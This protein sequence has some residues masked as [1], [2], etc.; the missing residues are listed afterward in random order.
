M[1]NKRT[2][3]SQDAQI[4]RLLDSFLPVRSS[5]NGSE[6]SGDTHLDEDS[7]AAFVEGNLNQRQS[8]PL[9]KHLTNCSFCRHITAELIKLDYV[10]AQVEETRSLNY[11]NET[12]PTKASEVLSGLL[13]RIFGDSA[14][15]V[16][17]H[18]EAETG[19]EKD[20]AKP[21]PPEENQK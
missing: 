1:E 9:V 12:E 16:F 10:F 6:L 11:A 20:S 18:N 13:S 17:A 7:L 2:I 15:A 8:Q 19:E 14:S 21:E 3:D 5:V 4:K